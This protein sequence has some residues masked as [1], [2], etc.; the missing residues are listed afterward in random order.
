VGKAG[1][2]WVVAVL[3]GVAGILLLARLD[4]G[5]LWQ[6]EAE[7]ALLARH[8]LQFGYPRAFDGRNLI[9]E[10]LGY[11][12]AHAWIYSPWLPFYLLAA[13]FAVAGES[14]GMARLP[15]ALCGLASI[16]LTWRLAC[17]LTEDRRIH[18]LSVALLTCS[19]PFLLHM[20][21][22]R[23]YALT[24]ALVLA[25]CLAYGRLLKRR[26]RWDP[27]WLGVSLVLLFHTNFGTFIPTFA[28]L[29]L[30]QMGW[31]DGPSRRRL[32]VI[33]GAVALLTLPWALFAWRQGFVGSWTLERAMDHLEYYVRVTNKY[34]MP[35]AFLAAASAAWALWRRVVAAERGGA[36]PWRGR[37]ALTSPPLAW[38]LIVMVAC[39]AAFLLIP[40]Q[41]HMR[42]LIPILPLLAIGEA[43]WLAVLANR[44]RLAGWVVVALAVFTNVLH[45]PHV[46]VPLVAFLDELTHPYTGP[47]EGVV[48]YLRR[49]GRPDEVV[50][51]P[52]DD[53]TLMFYSRLR[54]DVPSAFLRESYPEWIVIR[55]PWIPAEFFAS[56]YFG[57][58]EATYERIELDAP[59]IRWQNREDPGSHQFRTVRGAPR[60]VIY[61][62]RVPL[63]GGGP[64]SEGKPEV[65]PSDARLR[66]AASPSAGGVTYG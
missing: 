48:H 64:S 29:L 12:P 19:V 37:P 10:P 47:M 52:Y 18:R 38:A 58:I 62:R 21:Q 1:A 63:A 46:R 3:L 35:L 30:H 23:Y 32:V 13:V 40:N 28:A 66:L 5:Y 27:S 55:R 43:W 17:A 2:D 41:R 65:S 50:K 61:R 20:R 11:G 6:D 53:R 4:N 34:L 31:G 9:E 42:Y 15:F 44:L 39:H 51:I 57:R 54:V 45:S 8:T 7:T 25:V 36:G 33:A 56:E 26:T 14:T 59:D 49:H 22:C 16:W 24:T 60:V